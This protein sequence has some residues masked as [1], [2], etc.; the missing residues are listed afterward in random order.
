[1]VEYWQGESGNDHVDPNPDKVWYELQ[2]ALLGF[3]NTNIERTLDI[4]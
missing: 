4:C 1:M 3:L 2:M